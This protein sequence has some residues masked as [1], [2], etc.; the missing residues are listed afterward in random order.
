VGA[1]PAPRPPARRRPGH[2][3]VQFARGDQT[4]PN[5]AATA[6]IR[7]GDVRDRAT[8]L[9]N[10]LAFAADPTFP[11]NRHPFLTRIAGLLPEDL[12]FIP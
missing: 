10:D 1:A 7:G 9:R 6:L 11:K 5:P 12:G 4:A 8:F 2:V 3:I